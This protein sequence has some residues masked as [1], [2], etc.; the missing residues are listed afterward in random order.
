[1]N[2]PM[3]ELGPGETYTMDTR[4]FPCR[5]GPELQD[6]TDAGVIGKPLTAVRNGGNVELSGR[7]GVFFPGTLEAYLYDRSGNERGRVNM[8]AA[9]PKDLID[10]N[11]SIA[12]PE[13]VVRVSLHLVDNRNVDRGALGEAFLNHPEGA[14]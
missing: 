7:F 6:V 11:R 4:W 10:L 9:S 14:F 3:A 5:M 1:L 2:S 8:Q 13:T 12:A